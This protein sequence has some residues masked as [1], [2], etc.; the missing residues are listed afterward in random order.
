VTATFGIQGV[1]DEWERWN[2]IARSFG[3]LFFG[4][5][6]LLLGFDRVRHSRAPDALRDGKQQKGIGPLPKLSSRKTLLNGQEST[7][8]SRSMVDL[9]CQRTVI[10]YHGCDAAVAAKV[11]AGQTKLE[12]STNP[13]DWLGEGIYFWEHGPQRAFEWAAEQAD[14]SGVK[15]ETPAVQ[16]GSESP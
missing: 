16:G 12:S 1:V 11:L 13:Y 3:Y 6:L 4:M 10:G 9:K 8:T 15:V 7:N 14:L 2:G 5:G